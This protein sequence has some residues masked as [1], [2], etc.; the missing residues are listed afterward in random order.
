MIVESK[1]KNVREILNE[2]RMKDNSIGFVP[3]MG[4]L[5][6]GH[7]SL[8]RNSVNNE[9]FTVVSIYVNPTQFA[10]DEDFDEYPRDMERDLK[11]LEKEG[12]DL[13]FTPDDKEM[14]S[15]DF[16]TYVIPGKL[17]D[18]LCGSSRP[19]FFKGVC[20]IVTKLFNIINP[21][22][23]YFG[24]KDYQQYK[25]IDRMS[26]D[27]NMNVEVIACPIIR[28]DDG[29]AMSSRNR[30]LNREEREDALSLNLAL[31]KAKEL[32]DNGEKDVNKIKEMIINTINSKSKTD[33]DYVEVV[34]EKNLKPID[35]I[36]D[37]S[38]VLIALAVNVGRARL[39]DNTVW[40][41]D[42]K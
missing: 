26:K 42:D 17:S 33:I 41:R 10:P 29:I 11:L 24:Q 36:D 6:E 4:F 14:Y 25:I 3:T 32:L 2:I 1:I 40:E 8:I 9:D 31:K 20:T 13:V 28:E 5:H 27:L 16:Q 21:D 22:R 7:L 19:G 15:D 18:V 34:D 35:S 23:A 39:I 12:V 38:K 30:Y 37:V